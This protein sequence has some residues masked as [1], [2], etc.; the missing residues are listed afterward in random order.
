MKVNY[1]ANPFKS[2]NGFLPYLVDGNK[3]YCGYEKIVSHLQN[4]K[5]YK[6]ITSTAQLAYMSEQLNPYLMYEMF[7][8]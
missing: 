8:K 6:L 7:G 5:N 4:E 1:A 2:D 3:K